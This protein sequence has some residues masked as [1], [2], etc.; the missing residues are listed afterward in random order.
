MP[1]FTL[2]SHAIQIVL[3]TLQDSI[4]FDT[5]LFAPADCHIEFNTMQ[6]AVGGSQ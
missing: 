3:N 1:C 2:N 6:L 4:N 5:E